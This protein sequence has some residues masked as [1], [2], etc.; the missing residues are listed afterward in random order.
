MLEKLSVSMQNVTFLLFDISE[1]QD[2]ELKK[3]Y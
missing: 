3:I 1:Q 2:Q